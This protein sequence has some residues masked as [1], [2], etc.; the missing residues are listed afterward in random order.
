VLCC[1][2]QVNGKMRGTVEVSVGVDQAGAVAAALELA[3][4]QKQ[5]EV[6]AHAGRYSTMEA[7]ICASVIYRLWIQ[8]SCTQEVGCCRRAGHGST[9]W[10]RFMGRD[11]HAWYHSG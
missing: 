6:C 7:D 2:V 1:A 4:V 9:A 10:H 8:M 11:L 5:T 3:N